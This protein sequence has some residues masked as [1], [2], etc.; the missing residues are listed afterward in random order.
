MLAADEDNVFE[1]EL[2]FRQAVEL[3]PDFRSA[4]FNLA[5]LLADS[6]R[7]NDALEPLEQLL[8][9]H[10]DHKKGLILIGDIYTNF[11]KDF[12]KAEQYYERYIFYSQF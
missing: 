9:Y 7:S 6:H 12:I 8:H 10:P 3:K 11:K 2:W 4:L 1:A 5:L